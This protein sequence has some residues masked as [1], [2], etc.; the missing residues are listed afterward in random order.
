[1]ERILDS[2]IDFYRDLKQRS[3]LLAE[4]Q[5]R[6]EQEIQQYKEQAQTASMRNEE[7]QKSLSQAQTDRQVYLEELEFALNSNITYAAARQAGVDALNMKLQRVQSRL[8]EA[9]SEQTVLKS[10]LDFENDRITQA[11]RE[12][13]GE[14]QKSTQ[15]TSERQTL[16]ADLRSRQSFMMELQGRVERLTTDMEIAHNSLTV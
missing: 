11:T 9:K 14:R 3:Q 7:L 2:F 4:S 6:Q 12:L 15:L 10:A 13:T 1:M 16:E 5:E 8:M